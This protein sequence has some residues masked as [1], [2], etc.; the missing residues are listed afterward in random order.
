MNW[1]RTAIT[2]WLLAVGTALLVLGWYHKLGYVDL[3]AAAAR[4]TEEGRFDNRDLDR[5]EQNLFASRDLL[6]Y[7]QGVRAS[8]AGRLE[9][10]ARH[11]QEVIGRSRSPTLGAKAYY[12]LGN[13][14]ALEG[15]PREAV[16]MY[17]AA[18]RL[19]PSDWDAKSNLETLYAQFGVS[20]GEGTNAA[21]KQAR[22]L[23]E[24]G[25]ENDQGGPGTDTP[26]I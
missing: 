2:F 3:V 13:L 25:D 10:A 15:N 16:E 26:G 14:L 11:F 21:L 12:N 20:E 9:L 24:F 7:N 1:Y 18:L 23:V 4:A 8:A 17:R 6:A 22:D 19:D 5:A